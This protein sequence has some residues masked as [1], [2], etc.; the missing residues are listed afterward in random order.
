MGK[1]TQNQ[2]PKRIW[3]RS[4]RSIP[5]LLPD[6]C[7]VQIQ[8]EIWVAAQE[9][10][11][12]R[13]E[14]RCECCQLSPSSINTVYDN[15]SYLLFMRFVACSYS[16]EQG[17]DLVILNSVLTLITHK[18][19]KNVNSSSGTC[20]VRATVQT[21]PNTTG[22]SRPPSAY[23]VKPAHP[24]ACPT[25]PSASCSTHQIASMARGG[26]R[27]WSWINTVFRQQ[28]ELAVMGRLAT[29]LYLHPCGKE[30]PEAWGAPCPRLPSGAPG[31][32]LDRAAKILL[33]NSQKV[34]KALGPNP[35]QCR[36]LLS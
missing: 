3:V 33:S 31:C 19:D 10:L 14:S 7:I 35:R 11:W 18:R 5:P 25:R 9:K 22:A 32:T 28:L 24:G 21:M 12:P 8:T 1:K 15:C 26:G 13:E 27:E 4:S 6:Y 29:A 23:P 17:Q 20:P 36:L 34:L 2:N 16:A 30:T